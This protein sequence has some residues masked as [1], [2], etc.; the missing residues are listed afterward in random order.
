MRRKMT[1]VRPWLFALL[2]ACGSSQAPPDETPPAPEKPAAPPTERQIND[3]LVGVIDQPAPAFQVSQWLNAEPLSVEQLRG[4][5]VFVR[6]F[7][8]P[9][10]P[11]CS[12]TAPTLRALHERYAEKGLVVIGMYHHKEETPLDPTQVE[13]WVKQFGYQ[14]PIAIDRDW[15]TLRRWWLDGHERSF[16]SVSFLLDKT[17]VVRRVHLGGTIAPEGE[18]I[19]AIR[20]DVERLL[21]D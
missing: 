18:D 10:C 15:R 4:K 12:A 14:F 11:F 21:A 20:A 2:A 7:M 17:G 8:G 13:G 19:E 9:S 16:T 1:H 5:V 3:S 6:W